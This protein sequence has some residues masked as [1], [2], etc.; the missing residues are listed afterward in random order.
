MYK[1]NE[2]VGYLCGKLNHGLNV[3]VEISHCC[4]KQN[5][6][7]R[8]PTVREGNVQSCLGKIRLVKDRDLRK[9][10]GASHYLVISGPGYVT[11]RCKVT[12]EICSAF[13]SAIEAIQ[14]TPNVAN[15]FVLS[16]NPRLSLACGHPMFVLGGAQEPRFTFPTL[17][18]LLVFYER[19]EKVTRVR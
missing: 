11:R 18:E 17:K 2:S 1:N 15:V 10:H 14:K 19:F 6:G 13:T 16:E 4:D 8:L 7:K 5:D 3:L 12:R 9:R